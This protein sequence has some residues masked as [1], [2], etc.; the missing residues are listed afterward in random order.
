M[1]VL[2]EGNVYV[3]TDSFLSILCAAAD[4]AVKGITVQ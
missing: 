4:L 3:S 2:G 1:C